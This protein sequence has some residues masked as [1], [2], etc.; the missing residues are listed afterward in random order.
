[1][2]HSVHYT[3]NSIGG[4]PLVGG[5]R[6]TVCGSNYVVCLGKKPR[7]LIDCEVWMSEV[8]VLQLT[9]LQ[10][11]AWRSSRTLKASR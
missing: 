3:L 11:R 6:E 10:V 1:M 4:K 9:V 7:P 5:I 2:L 8:D